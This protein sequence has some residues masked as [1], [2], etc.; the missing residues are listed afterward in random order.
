MNNI[1][2]ICTTPNL[3]H[4]YVNNWNNFPQKNKEMVWVSDITSD[5]SFD[6]GFKYTE[7]EIRDVFNFNINVSKKH[8]WNSHGNRNIIWFYPHFRML[9][10]Y[11]KH[12]NYDFYWFFDDDVKVNDWG[13]FFNGTDND[14][15]DFLSYFC[16]KK[17]G[18]FSQENIPTID[19]RTFSKNLWFD[20]FPGDGDMLPVNTNELFGSFFPTT[21]F[22]NK[23]L[24]TLFEIH[25]EGYYGYSEGYVPT[26]LNSYGFKLNTL[27]N[28]DNTSNYFDVN[29]VDIQHKN[30]KIKW[31]WI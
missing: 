12:P 7:Q 30:I 13:E 2:C 11:L 17:D 20:R 22:S 29:E 15:S 3:Y 26:I 28:S 31:E 4:S 14:D 8:Y 1:H 27:I 21:R 23:A 6:I 18:V 10:F 25:K 9:N 16:F 24:S 19:D 5:L